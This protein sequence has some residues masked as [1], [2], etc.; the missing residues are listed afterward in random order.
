MEKILVT[1]STGQLGS[2]IREI[3][4]NFEFDYE[5]LFAGSADLDITDKDA[6]FEFFESNKPQYCI[7]ASAYTA[8]D[9][10]EKESEKAFSV[11]A[12]GVANLA[13][14]CKEF[15][16]VLI[17][18]STDYVFDGETEI[19]YAEDNFTNP[20]GMYGNSKLRGE[21]LAMELNPRTVVIR[22]SWLYSI[23]GKNF[24]K[25]MLNLFSQRDEIGVVAD[26]FGQ[27]THAADLAEAVMHIITS[28]KEKFGVFHFSNYPETTWYGFAS[29]IAELTESEIKIN[30]LTTEEYP[31]PA[32][33]PQRS[34]M[35]LDKIEQEYGI[36]LKHW[37]NSLEE[38][39]QI[40]HQKS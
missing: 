2:C 21:E 33:R 1:G 18:I 26:Q 7:N 19:S 31:T 25:T 36:E 4:P 40:L 9:L 10:A 3:A 6:V 34:T 28:G 22:T 27:P 14:A 24:V 13:E 20:L 30:R 15:K 38:C 11:N 29:K 5:F 17:H 16:S 35:S 37:E 23:Y 12:E 39:L 32:A 8:V